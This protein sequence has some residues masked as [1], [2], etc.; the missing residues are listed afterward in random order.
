VL[1]ESGRREVVG[2]LMPMFLALDRLDRS[3]SEEE[4]SVVARYLR[5]ATEAFDRVLA[6]DQPPTA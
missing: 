3:F 5:G 1:T 2:H 6:V 4:R